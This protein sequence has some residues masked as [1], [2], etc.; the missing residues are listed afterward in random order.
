MWIYSDYRI[1]KGNSLNKKRYICKF[2]KVERFKEGRGTEKGVLRDDEW[3]IMKDTKRMPLKRQGQNLAPL[4]INHV[5]LIHFT[6]NTYFSQTRKM[7]WK[8]VCCPQKARQ[9]Y[10]TFFLQ[11][12]TTFFCLFLEQEEIS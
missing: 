2:M 6:Q 11:K 4:T 7:A 3:R 8:F 9:P 12:K 1:L 5:D 10:N